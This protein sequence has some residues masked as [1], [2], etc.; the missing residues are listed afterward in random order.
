MPWDIFVDGVSTDSQPK[1]R[2]FGQSGG[3]Q[4]IYKRMY[5][6]T[7]YV[8][9][10]R[11]LKPLSI[12]ASGVA[13]A[14]T[15]CIAVACVRSVRPLLLLACAIVCRLLDEVK[16]ASNNAQAVQQANNQ[17]MQLCVC[18]RRHFG[19]RLS[20]GQFPRNPCSRPPAPQGDA[21]RQ[22]FVPRLAQILGMDTPQGGA[23]VT[24]FDRGAAL[25]AAVPPLRG[26]PPRLAVG[27]RR[28]HPSMGSWRRRGRAVPAAAMHSFEKEWSGRP[29]VG[30]DR[31]RGRAVPAATMRPS[32]KGVVGTP[33]GG[34]RPTP[35]PP[36]GGCDAHNPQVVLSHRH[37]LHDGEWRLCGRDA[38]G[39]AIPTTAAAR[40][41]RRWRA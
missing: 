23:F 29:P 25:C 2:G 10:E 32:G 28:K 17:A 35:R 16:G 9:I 38:P 41:R 40:W 20:R 26:G 30:C 3:E 22:G 5:V 27:Y 11:G 33:P 39:G 4:H 13:R 19:S 15:R 8:Y 24:Q 1:K 7:L 31:R 36:G 21:Y 37:L 12:Y 14:H 6:Y 18:V 34:V